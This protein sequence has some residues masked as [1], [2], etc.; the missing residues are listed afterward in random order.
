MGWYD[1]LDELQA[2][3]EA[4]QSTSKF[5]D[6][7]IAVE[8][9]PANLEALKRMRRRAPAVFLSIVSMGQGT[10]N[11]I[12]QGPMAIVADVYHEGGHAPR[13]ERNRAAAAICEQLHVAMLDPEKY[14]GTAKL[15]SRPR[16]FRVLNLSYS[17]GA[18][19]HKIAWWRAT[20]VADVES[21]ELS[22]E[23]LADLNTIAI[24]AHGEKFGGANHDTDDDESTQVNV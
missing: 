10:Q 3:L 5:P 2:N 13:V 12:P 16:D 18:D 17:S 23:T 6:C 9:G 19:E 11:Y 8:P 4:M 1:R 20:W 24:D 7:H 14:H 21:Q 22:P 15:M